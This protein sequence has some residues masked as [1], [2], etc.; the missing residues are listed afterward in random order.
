MVDGMGSSNGYIA[1]A[2]SGKLQDIGSL[3]DE[4]KLPNFKIW[5]DSQ[6]GYEGAMWNSMKAADGKVYFY[7]ILTV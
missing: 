7:L 2:N 3:I 4:G 5:L 1:A 6:G